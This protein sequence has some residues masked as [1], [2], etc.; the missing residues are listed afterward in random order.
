MD[1][2]VTVL[3]GD[4]DSRRSTPMSRRAMPPAPSTRQPS[5]RPM[6]SWRRSAIPRS[7]ASSCGSNERDGKPDYLKHLP[8]IRDYLRRALS[9]PALAELARFL[10]A[11]TACWRNGRCDRKTRR[12][13]PWCSPPGS[14]SA[15]GRSPTPCRSR[16]CGSPARR[17]STGGWTA[18]PRPASP[19]P[20][21]T[22]TIFPSR[23]SPMSRRAQ[24]RA[25]VI[26]DESDGLLDSAGGI[27]KALP[28]LGE[29]PFYILNADTFWIDRGPPNLRRLALAWDAARM[30]ILLML[31]DLHSGDRPQRRH[32]FPALRRTALLRARQGRSGR[33]DLCRRGDHPSAHLRGRAGRAAFA[34]RL[35][36]HGHRR[37]P[38]VRHEDA[39]PAG[40]PSARPTPFRWPKRRSPARWR[41][42]AMSG[43]R[44]PRLLHPARRAV[45]AD[46]GR[47]AARRPPDSRISAST[48]IRWRWPT[49]PSTCRRAAPR[50]S[51]AASSSSRLGG[52]SAILPVIRPLG[53]F[54][55]DEAAVRRRRRRRRSISR[56][57]S[58]QSTACC[59]WRR[60][61]APGSAGCRPMSP[62]CSTEEIVVP[63]SAADAIWLA[64]DLAGLMD[65]IETEGSDWAQAR[66]PGDRQPRRLVAG[67]ARFPA[68]RHRALAGVPGGARPLQSG[69]A[70]QRADPAGSRAAA[71]QSA[72]RA[73][74]RRRLHRLHPR[75]RRTAC[76]DRPPAARR[77]RAARPRPDAGRALLGRA[78]RQ[79]APSP[80]CSAIRNTAWPN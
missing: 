46:A 41:E 10:S 55:E 35:F 69:R 68:H 53:E 48:A 27:V 54:D 57:R 36:R 74:H 28:E 70:S 42:D 60:W 78:R 5:A 52:G 33:P 24:R 62:R 44:A 38:A 17:C 67:D 71:A 51:C 50:A 63:A 59:C 77:G 12:Q 72:R 34:Q 3:A 4:R 49:S 30:D 39:R 29:Q 73:G 14:A 25:I 31:A 6:R 23:S 80:P 16:W 15:C 21:S 2:R 32:R 47:G 8:R 58:R 19:R 75:H 26:S 45:P 7:S 66:R 65:E 40:S 37:R 11:R 64:R 9:H 13:P 43:R 56:R 18:W 61:C 1:A 22:S 20:S 79:P 76:G